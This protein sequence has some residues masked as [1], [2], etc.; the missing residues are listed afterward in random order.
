MAAASMSLFP[1]ASV[2]A[3]RSDPARSHR[4]SVPSE[5]APLALSRP[6]TVIMKIRC[7]RE[8]RKETKHLDAAFC[9]TVPDRGALIRE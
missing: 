7:E 5:I 4:V 6:S 8:L 9:C 1:C 2:L 3:T